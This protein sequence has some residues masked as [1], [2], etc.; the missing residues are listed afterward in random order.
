M[1]LWNGRGWVKIKVKL[2]LEQATKAQEGSIGI[3]YSSLNLS[4]RWG[5]VVIATPQPLNT[6]GKTQYP[7]YKRL[8]GPQGRSA[9]VQELA[10]H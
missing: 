5:W 3:A 4:A 6:P 2:T 7:S 10:P 9:P 1:L 8:D